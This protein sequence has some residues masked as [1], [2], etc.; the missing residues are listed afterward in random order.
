MFS[1]PQG[2]DYTLYS[3]SG[4]LVYSAQTSDASR[5]LR[6]D[7]YAVTTDVLTHNELEGLGEGIYDLYIEIDLPNGDTFHFHEKV[8]KDPE[9]EV[10]TDWFTRSDE[11]EVELPTGLRTGGTFDG[12]YE[13]FEGNTSVGSGNHNANLLT[14]DL[15]EVDVS[16]D[17]FTLLLESGTSFETYRIWKLNP[18]ILL[19]V[20]DV[21]SQIDRLHRNLKIDSLEHEDTDYLLWLRVGK[22]RFNGIPLT[23]DL[24]MTAAEGPIRSMWLDCVMLTALRV[25]YLEEGLTNY[26]Y[27]GAAV[28]LTVDVTQYLESLASLMESRIQE[29]GARLKTDLHKR[30]LTTGPGN[31]SVGGET[32]GVIG[33]TASP[34]SSYGGWGGSYRI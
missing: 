25:R 33:Q 12:K 32:L 9:T 7:V 23:T 28:N 6:G 15:E 10:P 3:P 29:D 13:L 14:L 27:S 2:L 16:L 22:D 18:S 11:L 5:T 30:E 21:R 24:S 1:V 4:V 31:W 34:V 26:E 20:A 19:A 17:P 8:G